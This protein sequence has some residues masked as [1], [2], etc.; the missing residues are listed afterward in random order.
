M[1]SIL[2]AQRDTASGEQKGG[3]LNISANMPPTSAR[4]KLYEI[5]APDDM[6]TA[7]PRSPEHRVRREA[8]RD[9]L[10]VSHR[11]IE[12]PPIIYE[13]PCRPC[14]TSSPRQRPSP[15]F[16]K[17]RAYSAHL[18]LAC[19]IAILVW[20]VFFYPSFILFIFQCSLLPPGVFSPYRG[21]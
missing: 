3:G 4:A 9:S 19:F 12:M 17:L 6:P 16:A 21:L 18:S 15:W 11:A 20:E 7:P 5:C 14:R 2:R 10:R 1:N 8:S 13:S